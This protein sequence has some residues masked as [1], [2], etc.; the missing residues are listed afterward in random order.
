MSAICG[1]GFV[2]AGQHVDAVAARLQDF[3]ATVEAPRPGDLVA[4]G[5]VIIGLD[6]RAGVSSVFQSLWMS[7]KIS[8]FNERIV[9]QKGPGG[10]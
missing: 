10:E 7:E 6:V 3:A 5:D 1:G 4:G 9:A 8:S 2:V